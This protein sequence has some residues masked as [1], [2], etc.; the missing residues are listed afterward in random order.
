MGGS[1]SRGGS[2]RDHPTVIGRTV[3]D[4]PKPLHLLVSLLSGLPTGPFYY[5]GNFVLE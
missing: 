3:I 2:L 5:L 4:R 1:V